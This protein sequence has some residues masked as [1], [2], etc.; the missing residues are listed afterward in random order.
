[1]RKGGESTFV[2]DTDLEWL[3]NQGFE[4]IGYVVESNPRTWWDFLY[5][6][7]NPTFGVNLYF[8]CNPTKQMW[9]SNYGIAYKSPQQA[10]E[11]AFWVDQTPIYSTLEFNFF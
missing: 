9:T 10:L 1:M 2:A 5:G 6:F 11:S 3:T 7:H 8:K 4:F